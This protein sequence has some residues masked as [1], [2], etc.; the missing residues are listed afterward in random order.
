MGDLVRQALGSADEIHIAVAFLRFSGLTLL[1]KELSVFLKRGGRLRLLVSTYLNVTQ[2]EALRVLASLEGVD[3]RLQHG[4]Q[5]F[6]AKYYMFGQ[7]EAA[8]TCWVGSSN[9]TKNGLYTSVEWNT[10]H[11]DPASVDACEQLFEELWTRPD[12]VDLTPEVLD[13]YARQYCAAHATPSLPTVFPGLTTPVP[14]QA[15][16]EALRAL[17]QLRFNGASR[18]AV[19]VATGLGKTHL[20]AFAYSSQCATQFRSYAPPKYGWMRHP[21]TRSRAEV[22]LGV[23]ASLR[24]TFCPSFSGFLL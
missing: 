16:R 3:L 19:I 20:A 10:R 14:N 13:H 9:F 2:P 11:D 12:V 24:S 15:Q 7:S 23:Q 4:P 22:I 21:S 1:L 6:H 17:R 5:G 18:A 8:R